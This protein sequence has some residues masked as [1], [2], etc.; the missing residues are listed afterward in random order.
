MN[1]YVKAALA[2][3]PSLLFLVIIPQYLLS[4][5]NA[6][7]AASAVNAGTLD[8]IR[9]NTSIDV[10]A[11]INGLAIFGI[12]LAG[13]AAIS[14]WSYKWSILKPASSSAHMVG[15]FF[16]M[17]YFIGLGNPLTFGIT[18]LTLV[19]SNSSITLN[20]TLTFLTVAVGI[21]VALKIIQKTMKYLEDRRNHQLDLQGAGGPSTSPMGP[22]PVKVPV[23]SRE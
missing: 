1:R 23:P 4:K 6:A 7:S 22:S 15:S 21:A 5:V 9:A 8:Q 18:K 20:L 10:T 14:A 16:L 17:L 3:I 2:T 12:V 13:L 11:F 19:S